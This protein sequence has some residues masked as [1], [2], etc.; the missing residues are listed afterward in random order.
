M[1]KPKS[2]DSYIEVCNRNGNLVFSAVNYQN[3]WDG[4]YNDK[5]LPAATYYYII[6][7]GDGSDVFKGGVAIVR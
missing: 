6:E 5:D 3:D 4:K 1:T 2:K 7:L